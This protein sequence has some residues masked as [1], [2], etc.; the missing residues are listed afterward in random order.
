MDVYP[1]D[2]NEVLSDAVPVPCPSDDLIPRGA[3]IPLYRGLVLGRVR[4]DLLR[5]A[6]F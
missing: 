1:A 4:H 2:F 3:P 5:E 6:R